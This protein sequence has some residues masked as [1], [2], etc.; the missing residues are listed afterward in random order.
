[1]RHIHMPLIRRVLFLSF[2]EH[3]FLKPL[4]WGSGCCNC[5]SRA[6]YLCKK[7]SCRG[8]FGSW[9][10]KAFV[11]AGPLP[12]KQRELITCL[13]WRNRRVPFETN[14][15]RQQVEARGN[16]TYPN[17]LSTASAPY[18][19]LL[20]V[21]H[22]PTLWTLAGVNKADICECFY[23]FYCGVGMLLGF[24]VPVTVSS[25]RTWSWKLQPQP[26]SESE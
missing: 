17:R 20:L 3:F 4:T 6:E 26:A 9:T 7:T 19:W 13:T 18:I 15:R 5:V 11:E 12:D 1:M 24:P 22:F 23:S 8:S 21:A 10:K 16:Y 25:G 14:K 2:L